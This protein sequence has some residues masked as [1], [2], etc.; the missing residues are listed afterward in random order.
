MK[1]LNRFICDSCNKA[2]PLTENG[3][4]KYHTLNGRAVC[5]ECFKK[6]VRFNTYEEE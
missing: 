4:T 1:K 5:E 3:F 2:F 6:A